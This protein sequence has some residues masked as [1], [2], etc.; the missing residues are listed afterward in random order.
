MQQLFVFNRLA[1]T[2]GYSSEIIRHLAGKLCRATLSLREP[3][4]W[5]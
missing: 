2:Q 3:V 4:V 1:W 5:I